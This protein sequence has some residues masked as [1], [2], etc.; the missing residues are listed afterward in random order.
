M[1]LSPSIA[2]IFLAGVLAVGF[3]AGNARKRDRTPVEY[4]YKGKRFFLSPAE[5]KFYDALVAA[6]GHSFYVFAQVH[7]PTIVDSKVVGQNW[8]GAFRHIDEKSVD[9]VL[10]DKAYISPKLAI[11]LDDAS[12]RRV[13]R[14]LRDKEVERILKEAGVPLLRLQTQGQFSPADISRMVAEA[15]SAHLQ[16]LPAT[17]GSSL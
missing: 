15:L 6:V 16:P 9:F 5:H 13:D 8:R 11:E 4:R 10:C 17:G 2:A 3:L 7:L 12:H 1:G 14:N